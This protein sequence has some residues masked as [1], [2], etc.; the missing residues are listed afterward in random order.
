MITATIVRSLDRSV[1]VF[2]VVLAAIAV[3]VPILN[4]ALPPS[5]LERPGDATAVGQIADKIGQELPSVDV[6]IRITEREQF[7]INRITSPKVVVD[8][9]NGNA[10]GRRLQRQCGC[11]PCRNP[12]DWRRRGQS[13]TRENRV[14]TVSI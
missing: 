11:H 4:L 12:R 13:S 5:S 7:F 10:G 8:L 1:T 2:L 14:T 6:T 3:L 9:G